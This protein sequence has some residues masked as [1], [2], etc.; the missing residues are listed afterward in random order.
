M[1]RMLR[2]EDLDLGREELHILHLVGGLTM[3]CAAAGWE[4]GGVQ[5]SDL[6]WQI[7]S[8]DSLA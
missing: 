4:L 6:D 8:P 3:L 5:R 2:V 1:Q 7:I